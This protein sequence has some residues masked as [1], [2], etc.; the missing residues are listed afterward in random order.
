MLAF[1]ISP[2]RERFLPGAVGATQQTERGYDSN[3][4]LTRH[5]WWLPRANPCVPGFLLRV[6]AAAR[7]LDT[8]GNAGCDEREPLI[9]RFPRKNRWPHMYFCQHAR[10]SSCAL[11][12]PHCV[13]TRA[14]H[15]I[16]SLQQPY[17][18]FGCV[19]H[20]QDCAVQLRSTSRSLPFQPGDGTRSVY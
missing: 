17:S 5:E 1:T 11:R 18:L 9:P 2:G 16:V 6:K 8:I 7:G 4:S 14:S 13:Y 12:V 15:A 10:I 19:L 3:V 20:R